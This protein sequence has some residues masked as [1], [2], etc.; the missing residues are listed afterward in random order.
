MLLR[1]QYN[2]SELKSGNNEL[3]LWLL[4]VD[5]IELSSFIKNE[6]EIKKQTFISY[7]LYVRMKRRKLEMKKLSLLS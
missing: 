4:R 3:N 7:S 2:E 1:V 6:N 5:Y